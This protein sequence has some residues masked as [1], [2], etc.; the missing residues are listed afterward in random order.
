M[1]TRVHLYLTVHVA[2]AYTIYVYIHV[3]CSHITVLIGVL[4]QAFVMHVNSIHAHEDIYS[5]MISYD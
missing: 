1:S 2:Y 4:S 5:H 3:I